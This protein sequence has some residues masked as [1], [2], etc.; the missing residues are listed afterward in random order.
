MRKCQVHANV[1]HCILKVECLC[2]LGSFLLP[3]TAE[4]SPKLSFSTH[5]LLGTEPNCCSGSAVKIQT[6]LH[7]AG[8]W[9]IVCPSRLNSIQNL[10]YLSQFTLYPVLYCSLSFFS[11]LLSQMWQQQSSLF[12]SLPTTL[13]SDYFPALLS[14]FPNPFVQISQTYISLSQLLICH[15]LFFANT[16]LNLYWFCPWS[17]AIAPFLQLLIYPSVPLI[18][19]PSPL[20]LKISLSDFI[21]HCFSPSFSFLFQDEK[22]TL[23]ILISFEM[24]FHK[25]W[26]CHHGLSMSLFLVLFFL[27][28][29]LLGLT[30]FFSP[31]EDRLPPSVVVNKGLVLDENSMKK[32][33]TLQLSASDQDS[34]PGELIYRITKQTSL[35][36]LEHSAS[37]GSNTRTAFQVFQLKVAHF[38]DQQVTNQHLKMT[39]SNSSPSHYL[40]CCENHR[41]INIRIW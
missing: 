21:L 13:P 12:I 29:L 6:S 36:H 28:F 14:I 7:A 37:P 34:E 5:F 26:K 24:S 16:H 17:C 35:G 11:P 40:R 23:N 9:R 15:A 32:L 10:S 2:L 1:V 39:Y 18:F 41:K 4:N 33:T 8:D 19:S 25:L 27:S 22:L 3:V 31:P 38:L 30:F 20:P